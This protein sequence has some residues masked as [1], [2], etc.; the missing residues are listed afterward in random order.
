ML[1]SFFASLRAIVQQD[2]GARGLSR[3]FAALPEDLKNACKSLAQPKRAHVA[4]VTGFFIPSAGRAETDGPFG[5]VLLAE[6]V[7]RAGGE[8]LLI[9]EPW[10]ASTLQEAAPLLDVAAVEPG[11]EP[12]LPRVGSQEPTHL[13]SVERPG[14]A[15]CD[16]ELRT[17]RGV[18]IT[19]HHAAVH[20]WFEDEMR[21]CATIAVG[22]G[23][24]EIGMGRLPRE[25]IEAEITE[26]RRIACR[27]E[28]DQLIVAGL[29]NWGAYAL[30]AGLLRLKEAPGAGEIFDEEA[31]HGRWAPIV[32]RGA[33][34]DGMAGV[35]ALAV[36]GQ[37]WEAYIRSFRAIRDL[38]HA[39]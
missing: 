33:L 6:A 12:R 5:A 32:E 25:L 4:I 17:M 29:S 26:G 3:L 27:T 23:G 24:N 13:V 36:D 20:R 34:V 7:R 1:E 31:L 22:D 30:A 10:L 37:P 9:A 14:P 2:V 19:I 8:A 35:P 15:W 11:T 39:K 28:A 18:E 21:P 16:G 38:L